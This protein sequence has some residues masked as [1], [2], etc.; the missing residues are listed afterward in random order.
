MLNNFFLSLFFSFVANYV[1]MKFL[2]YLANLTRDHF[3]LFH[4][5]HFFRRATTLNFIFEI[6]ENIFFIKIQEILGKLQV[7]IFCPR[8]VA[9]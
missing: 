3:I 2:A 1:G 4:Q 8:L 5:S 9:C 7:W 6:F